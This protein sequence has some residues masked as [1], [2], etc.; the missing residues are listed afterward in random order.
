MFRRAQGF[1]VFSEGWGLYAETLG[2]ELGM[3]R[4][5][6][7]RFGFYTNQ[8]WRAARLV[9][10][11]GIHAQ[12]W[13]RQQAIEYMLSATGMERNRVEWEVDRYISQPAQA[14]AYMIGQLKII[15]LREKARRALGPRFDV[16]RFHTAI[17]DQGQ[18]PLDLLERVIDAWIEEQQAQQP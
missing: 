5:P 1:T 11:T 10:D 16:R 2:P 6:Y 18:L 14:L 13:T 17:L 8:A 7:S 15:E 9:V 3:Y 12:G 4:D